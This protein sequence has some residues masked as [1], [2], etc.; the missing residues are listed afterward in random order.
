MTVWDHPF[1]FI[2]GVLSLDGDVFRTLSS[3]PGGWLVGMLVVLAA[4]L[5]EALGQ[6]VVLFANRVRPRRFVAS[7]MLT[8]LSYPVG[9][10]L[11]T[12]STVFLADRFFGQELAVRQILL[13]ALW[14]FTPHLFGA[15]IL[16]PYAGGFIALCLS[17]WSFAVMTT[18]IHTVFT[19]SLTQA[20]LCLTFGWLLWQLL[21][22]SIGW[23]AV[24]VA[25]W[26]RSR[27]AGEPLVTDREGLEQ[28]FR[29]HK[30]AALAAS[31]TEV[32][33]TNDG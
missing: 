32:G 10:L 15:L 31:K 9:L 8:A 11:F 21:R 26:L 33:V 12:L 13:V 22:R 7:L 2:A 19:L 25:R 24:R 27:V 14:S 30:N 4:G 6:S 18:G 16:T 23:P 17:A 20:A 29:S 28:L 1:R 5:S 3:D